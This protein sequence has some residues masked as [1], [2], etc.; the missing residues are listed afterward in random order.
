MRN[1]CDIGF[2]TVETTWQQHNFMVVPNTKDSLLMD[3]CQEQLSPWNRQGAHSDAAA[4]IGMSSDLCQ[5]HVTSR[6]KSSR[7]VTQSHSFRSETNLRRSSNSFP[8]TPAG[9][10]L[11]LADTINGYSHLSLLYN[12]PFT[13]TKNKE[14]AVWLFGNYSGCSLVSHMWPGSQVFWLKRGVVLPKR[15]SPNWLCT[16]WSEELH[17]A[18]VNTINAARTVYGFFSISFRHLAIAVVT[19]Q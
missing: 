19:P 11:A 6:V 3:T 14:I 2:S 12:I 8:V 18:Y 4:W 10:T 15:W 13:I 9:W 7:L 17:G 5:Y 1:W 16:F